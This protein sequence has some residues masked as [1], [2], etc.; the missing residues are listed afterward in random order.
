MIVWKS[1]KS[2]H[3]VSELIQ[4][5]EGDGSSGRKIRRRRWKERAPAKEQSGSESSEEELDEEEEVSD[6]D[7]SEN[8]QGWFV[9]AAAA[10]QEMQMFCRCFFVTSGKTNTPN[11]CNILGKNFK[12]S[13]AL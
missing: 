5:R 9:D 10:E 12:V 13:I 6:T 1:N 7:E 11:E 3:E 4:Q 2:L 8:E